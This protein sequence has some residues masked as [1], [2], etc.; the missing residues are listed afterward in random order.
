MFSTVTTHIVSFGSSEQV[1]RMLAFQPY[2]QVLY[3]VGLLLPTEIIDRWN[4]RASWKTASVSLY[5][6]PVGLLQVSALLVA[7]SASGTTAFPRMCSRACVVYNSSQQL[8]LQFHAGDTSN[9]VTN[10]EN[11]K[12]Q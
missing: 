3:C 12:W 6:S 4:C 1:D 2:S 10:F 9:Q 5:H 7:T 11:G 8:V